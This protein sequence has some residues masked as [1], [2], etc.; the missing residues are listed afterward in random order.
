MGRAADPL[1]HVDDVE[2]VD[3]PRVGVGPAGIAVTAEVERQKAKT[4]GQNRGKER[5]AA[6]A[7]RK[8]NAA[9]LEASEEFEEHVRAAMDALRTMLDSTPDL[10]RL[11]GSAAGMSRRAILTRVG[12]WLAAQLSAV[13][14]TGDYFGGLRL[15]Y[16]GRPKVIDSFAEAERALS[17]PLLEDSKP[18]EKSNG[19][20][21]EENQSVSG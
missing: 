16:T 14:Q 18:K 10:L 2:N 17:A 1:Q 20:A 12:R 15:H 19:Q 11:P 8:A 7:A 3:R 9:R 5:E 21:V 6:Q 13:A 4:L